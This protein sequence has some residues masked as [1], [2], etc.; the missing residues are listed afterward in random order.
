M[1]DAAEFF[2]SCY[3]NKDLSSF[4]SRITLALQTYYLGRTNV[5][6][7]RFR[8]VPQFDVSRSQHNFPFNFASLLSGR[9]NSALLHST[10]KFGTGAPAN[11][12]RPDKS[13]DTSRL[14]VL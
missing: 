2:A 12:Q 11:P 14:E 8:F 10:R 1:H 6:N 4:V 9:T 5:H 3:R 7:P 13:V